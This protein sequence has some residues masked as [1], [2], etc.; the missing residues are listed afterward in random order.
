[1]QIIGNSFIVEIG[2]FINVDILEAKDRL[3]TFF[4]IKYNQ[5]ILPNGFCTRDLAFS[6]ISVKEQMWILK[7]KTKR[8]RRK[9]W[10]E[11]KQIGYMFPLGVNYYRASNL[12]H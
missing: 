6:R 2:L 11:H 4:C 5:Q 3:S 8:R 10:R 7:T 1:M 9:R 12:A